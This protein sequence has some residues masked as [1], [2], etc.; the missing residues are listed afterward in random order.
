MWSAV[1]TTGFLL[2]TS[3][4]SGGPCLT[5]SLAQSPDLVLRT[6]PDPA[7]AFSTPAHTHTLS[8]PLPL[9]LFVCVHRLSSSLGWLGLPRR[10]GSNIRTK[11]RECRP[12]RKPLTPTTGQYERASTTTTLRRTRGEAR[13]MA[14]GDS[15]PIF[16]SPPEVPIPLFSVV[17]CSSTYW[18]Q[19]IH[20]VK[21]TGP[22]IQ[23]QTTPL[24]THH[25]QLRRL[26]VR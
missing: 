25:G 8:L 2:V 24:S 18:G 11:C 14:N 3:R 15:V 19:L 1:S 26:W 4:K 13:N 12:S 9:C 5:L 17:L 16:V 21:A 6:C 22:I 7:Q 20:R 10:T 23:Q